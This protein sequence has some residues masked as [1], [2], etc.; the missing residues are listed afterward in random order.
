MNYE[1][2]KLMKGKFIIFRSMPSTHVILREA[3]GEDAESIIQKITLALWVRGSVA[4][5]E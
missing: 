3:E 5:G 1:Y 2:S 4:E